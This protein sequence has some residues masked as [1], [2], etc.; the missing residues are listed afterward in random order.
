MF[1]CMFNHQFKES[2]LA[3]IAR[4]PFLYTSCSCCSLF[5]I[6]IIEGR[7]AAMKA[8]V[9]NKSIGSLHLCYS[10]SKN[11]IIFKTLTVHLDSISSRNPLGY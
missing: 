4:N 7:W 5:S 8:R 3:G 10:E 2:R 9:C 11:H 1:G 6:G